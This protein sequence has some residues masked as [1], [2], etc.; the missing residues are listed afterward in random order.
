MM[1]CARA[2]QVLQV[3]GVGGQGVFDDDDWQM[4]MLATELLEPAAGGMALAVVLGLAVLLNNRL[5][6]QGDDFLEVRMDQGGPQQLMGIGDPA[7][8]M[9]LGQARGAR[10]LGGGEVGRAI[11]RQEI[12]AVEINEAFE[13]L[14]AL[15]AT[16]HIVEAGPQVVGIQRIEDVPHLRVAGDL[17]DPINGTEVVEGIAAPVI[18]GQ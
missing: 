9:V 13:D 18:E 12:T 16:E 2:A 6:S 4:G 7:A 14:A 15:E 1:K 5:G 3:R 10:D 11:E 17:I 8:A